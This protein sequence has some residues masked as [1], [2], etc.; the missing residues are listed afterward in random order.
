MNKLLFLLFLIL[1]AYFA[2]CKAGV[3]VSV[4]QETIHNAALKYVPQMTE[5]LKD[6][7]IPNQ[8]IEVS[9]GLGTLYADLSNIHFTINEVPK[10]KI[11]TKLEKQNKIDLAILGVD[12]IKGFGNLIITFKYLF[13]TEPY[14]CHVD[15]YWINF[16][17]YMQPG[18]EE[19]IQSK[20]RYVP[21][22]DVRAFD[23]DMDFDFKLEDSIL[24]SI[25][26]LAKGP[27][28]DAIKS[29]LLSSIKEELIQN[30]REIFSDIVQKLPIFMPLSEDETVV[31]DYSLVSIPSIENNMLI[32]NSRGSVINLSIPDSVNPPYPMPD[33]LPYRGKTNKQVQAFADSY[34]I[35][36]ALN[37]LSLSNKL[38]TLIEAEDI[39]KTS[40]VQL[41]TST[42]E[43]LFPGIKE[44]YGPNEPCDLFINVIQPLEG[45]ILKEGG[46]NLIFN[47]E[48]Q[49]IIEKNKEIPVDFS[50]KMNIDAD[51]KLLENGVIQAQIN[52][53]LLSNMKIISSKID[54]LD[55]ESIEIAFN[56]I[57]DLMIPSINKEYLSTLVV[58]L[59]DLDNDKLD[60]SELFVNE[61]NIELG[62][63]PLFLPNP[64]NNFNFKPRKEIIINM[65]NG[66]FI[67]TFKSISNKGLNKTFLFLYN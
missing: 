56:F 54:N 25:V 23:I 65:I 51:I 39:P 44:L 34:V 29:N 67:N 50:G 7:E 2:S 32:V 33:D 26:Q 42:L 61:S 62:V 37:T 19:S 16:K 40:P 41:N 64:T 11:T 43:S 60:D 47:V 53:A 48:V 38:N 28:K 22:F 17:A 9:V 10:D 3:K 14:Q 58:V 49:L 4:P 46:F 12:G 5:S 52:D 8:H 20:G 55:L 59:P 21:A 63:N 6:L 66:I 35:N 13:I 1:C 27:I 30:G 57:V 15:I 36:V 45:I 31:I 18:W 24:G